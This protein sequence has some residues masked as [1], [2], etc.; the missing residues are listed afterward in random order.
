MTRGRAPFGAVVLVLV[1]DAC[2]V[3]DTGEAERLPGPSRA[4]FTDE[5]EPL[6]EK[7]CGDGAC[8]GMDRPYALYAVGQ[9]RVVAAD[10][11]SAE[12]L[13][14]AEVDANYVATL[15]F[16]DAPTAVDTTL[17]RKALGLGGPGGHRGGV[18]FEAPSDPECRAVVRWIEGGSPTL[19]SLEGESE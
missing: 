2:A 15:G 17:I 19:A 9:R 8:H 1:A 4:T 6:L 3:V 10:V 14:R 5:A 11:F 7:R 12:P 16:L 18:V 13:T